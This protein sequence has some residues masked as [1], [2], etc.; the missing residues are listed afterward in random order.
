MT[1]FCGMFPRHLIGL[2]ALLAAITLL[3]AGCGDN[4]ATTSSAIQAKPKQHAEP[5]PPMGGVQLTQAQL[6]AVAAYVWSLSH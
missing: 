1:S 5:M 6:G 4:R 3:A 2:L